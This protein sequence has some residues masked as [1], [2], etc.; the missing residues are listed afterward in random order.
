MLSTVINILET[1][2]DGLGSIVDF[3]TAPLDLITSII[4]PAQDTGSASGSSSSS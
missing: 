4:S 2:N 1:L 3:I